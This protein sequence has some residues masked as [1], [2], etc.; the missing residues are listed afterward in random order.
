MQSLHSQPRQLFRQLHR[1]KLR[2]NQ[3]RK[4]LFVGRRHDPRGRNVSLLGDPEHAINDDDLSLRRRLHPNDGLY[5]EHGEE[6]GDEHA[7][8]VLLILVREPK[9]RRVLRVR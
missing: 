7:R 9:T 3:R 4:D 8:H 6:N 1:M 2:I 5:G